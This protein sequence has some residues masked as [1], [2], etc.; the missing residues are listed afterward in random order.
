M[1]NELEGYICFN[2]GRV[3]RRVYEHYDSRLSPFNLTTP[4]YMVFNALWIGDGITIGELG[5]RVALDGS[6]ITGILDR[7]EKNG[8]V[9]RRPN[10]EDRRSALVYLTDK[11]RE[12]GPRIIGFADELDATIRKNFSTQDMVVFERVLRELGRSQIG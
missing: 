3:M 7:M 10:A 12:V 2:V 8:Y 4:Q 11:A 6:T 1:E 5:Q 9:E